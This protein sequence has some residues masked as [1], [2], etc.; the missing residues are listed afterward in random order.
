MKNYEGGNG[1]C[2]GCGPQGCSGVNCPDGGQTYEGFQHQGQTQTRSVAGN[3][4]VPNDMTLSFSGLTKDQ[5]IAAMSADTV[6]QGGEHSDAT[7]PGASNLLPIATMDSTSLDGSST[8]PSIIYDRMIYAG[9]LSRNY[10][11]GDFFRGDLAI[12]PNQ[13]GWFNVSAV[14]KQ[15]LNP[16][17]INVMAG[18]NNETSNAL[19]E[20]ISATSGDSTFAGVPMSSISQTQTGS[21][22]ADV[23]VAAFP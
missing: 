20:L 22:L 1:S 18:N 14:P 23:T 3:P 9:R 13:N 2:G 4:S 8:E 5:G 16:G 11:H 10:A 21:S 19:A 7:D 17:A 15:D 12:V 6:S